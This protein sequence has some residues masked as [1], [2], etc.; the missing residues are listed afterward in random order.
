[1]SNYLQKKTGLALSD[2][3]LKQDCPGADPEDTGS[4][5]AE[6]PTLHHHHA[7]PPEQSVHL[8]LPHVK[9]K[10]MTEFEKF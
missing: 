5:E 1:M 10:N 2:G 9:G 8:R 4:D 7:S 6:K 3:V